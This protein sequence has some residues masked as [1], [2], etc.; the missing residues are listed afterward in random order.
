[1]V[2][3]FAFLRVHILCWTPWEQYITRFRQKRERE[4]EREFIR[5]TASFS[6]NKIFLFVSCI[7]FP[8]TISNEFVNILKIKN[9]NVLQF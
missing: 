9:V 3:Y 6:K 1:M 8:F 4:R 5:M 2:F 7:T